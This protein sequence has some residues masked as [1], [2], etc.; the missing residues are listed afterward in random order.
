MNWLMIVIIACLVLSLFEGY[1]K[2]FMR[3]VFSLVSW[4]LV[5]VICNI[6]T[7]MVTDLLI[8]ETNI[9]ESISLS[10]SEKINEL[11]AESEVNEL[12]ETTPEELRI[13]LFGE[14]GSLEETLASNGES[15]V[16]ATSMVHTIIS[17]IGLIIVIVVARVLL[18]VVDGILGI[19]SKLPLI[20]SVDKLLGIVCGGIK[21]VL[22]CWVILTV[23]YVLSFTGANTELAG[24]IAESQ[25][26]SWLQ[27]N[28]YILKIV[29]PK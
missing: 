3:T 7:P 20:G 15:V 4:I 28:N 19:A 13:A 12:E 24:F 27:E 14:N 9:E 17:A 18:I 5:L 10:I 21:G 25:L 1:K 8:K 11:I 23:V 16:Q 26:L 6:A 29:M 2:G 22:I